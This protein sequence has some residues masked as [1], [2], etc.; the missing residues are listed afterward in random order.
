MNSEALRGIQRPF[1]HSLVSHD[2]KYNRWRFF[3]FFPCFQP[4]SIW[5]HHGRD[6]VKDKIVSSLPDSTILFKSLFRHGLH[7]H[8]ITKQIM[9]L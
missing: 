2:K 9:R 1:H 5:K 6:V 4:L 7:T 3:S 8:F